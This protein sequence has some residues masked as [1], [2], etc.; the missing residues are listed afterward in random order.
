MSCRVWVKCKTCG[1]DNGSITILDKISNERDT[2]PGCKATWQNS[3]IV[4]KV[5]F[6]EKADHVIWM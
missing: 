2:C 1:S 3:Q 6:S 4:A 5:N